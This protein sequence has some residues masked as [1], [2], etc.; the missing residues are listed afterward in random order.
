MTRKIKLCGGLHDGWE[1]DRPLASIIYI[2]EFVASSCAHERTEIQALTSPGPH[3]GVLQRN[4]RCLDCGEDLPIDEGSVETY[5]RRRYKSPYPIPGWDLELL[6]DFIRGGTDN[7]TGE[8]VTPW[9]YFDVWSTDDHHEQTLD[10]F[11]K[12]HGAL[13]WMESARRDRVARTTDRFYH[14]RA[15]EALQTEVENLANITR[16]WPKGGPETNDN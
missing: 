5:L 9:W 15:E 16:S 6:E 12:L 2:H 3:G 8:G 10:A 13:L 4:V 1:V 14:Q 11:A 7:P